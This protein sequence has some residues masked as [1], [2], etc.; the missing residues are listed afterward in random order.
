MKHV[1]YIFLLRILKIPIWEDIS[2]APKDREILIKS[3][4]GY[5][6]ISEYRPDMVDGSGYGS[7]HSC[8][9]YYE[10]WKPVA[11]KDME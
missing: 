8:C 10:D 2:T 4:V 3:S 9:G 6:C 11:W 7:I 1:I 5:I